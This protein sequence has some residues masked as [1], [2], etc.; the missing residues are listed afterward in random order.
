MS[1]REKPQTAAINRTSRGPIEF[2]VVIERDCGNA[3]T[4]PVAQG[5]YSPFQ[6]EQNGTESR[7]MR[8]AAASSE[9]FPARVNFY[10]QQDSAY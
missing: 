1:I 6:H 8:A 2:C 5:G 7:A 10:A 9:H 4:H 3:H